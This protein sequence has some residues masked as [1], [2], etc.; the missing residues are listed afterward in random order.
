MAGD[1]IG[2]SG[3]ISPRYMY[4][5]DFNRRFFVHICILDYSLIESVIVV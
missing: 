5:S 4:G 2:T 3:N 1:D